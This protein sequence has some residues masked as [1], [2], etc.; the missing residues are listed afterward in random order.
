VRAAQKNV[1][2]FI[3]RLGGFGT[4][5]HGTADAGYAVRKIYVCHN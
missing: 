4:K 5:H 3:E 2:Q 1:D